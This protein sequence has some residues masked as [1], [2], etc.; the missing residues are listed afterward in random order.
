LALQLFLPLPEAFSVAAKTIPVAWDWHL[1]SMHRKG[2]LRRAHP[3]SRTEALPVSGAPPV[4]NSA[5][6]GL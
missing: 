4:Q 5:V 3:L 2:S 6:I 1:G